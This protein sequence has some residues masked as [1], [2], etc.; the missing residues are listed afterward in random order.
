MA[1]AQAHSHF[2]DASRQ[3]LRLL[4]GSTRRHVVRDG[5]RW[6]YGTQPGKGQPGIQAP[7]KFGKEEEGWDE[8]SH[9]STRREEMKR[10]IELT[11]P[12]DTLH[13]EGWIGF[14]ACIHAGWT[15]F[16]PTPYDGEAGRGRKQG[17]GVHVKAIRL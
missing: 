11:H 17:E 8:V 16:P 9:V 12:S 4:R 3:Q 1:L 5:I 15:H 7:N 10:K 6:D 2:Q 13:R 14:M